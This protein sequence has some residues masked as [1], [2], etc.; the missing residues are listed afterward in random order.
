MLTH[1]RRPV[2]HLLPGATALLLCLSLAPAHAQA[3]VSA[4]VAEANKA[5][6]VDAVHTFQIS[7]IWPS[8]LVGNVNWKLSDPAWKLFLSPDGVNATSRLG[9][10]LGN[11]IKAQGIG[12]LEEVETSNNNDRKSTQTE[13]DELIA[14][15]KP[16]LSLTV[17]ATQPKLSA[18]QSHWIL[19][20]LGTVSE[21][22]GSGDWTPRGGRANIKLV[23]SSTAKDIS[24]TASKDATN[25][26]IIAPLKEVPDWGTKLLKGFKRNAK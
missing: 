21:F 17:E 2:R 26:S 3:S 25:F 1:F 4:Q 19:N 22:V 13:V 20:Y 7:D 16:K 10:N 14:Q 9:R 6:L 15:A 18:A 24:S 23:F 8:K 5:D 11:Y 12:D